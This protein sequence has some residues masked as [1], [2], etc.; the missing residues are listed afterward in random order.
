MTAPNKL[1][2]FDIDGTLVNSQHANM[3]AVKETWERAAAQ[4]PDIP[5]SC[6]T[7]S[8]Q[9]L[10]LTAGYDFAMS[11]HN[12]ASRKASAAG[13]GMEARFK[14]EDDIT[15]KAEQEF[16][17]GRLRE[18]KAQGKEQVIYDGVPQM[19]ETLKKEGY[20]L[21]VITKRGEA[22]ATPEQ[23]KLARYF[24]EVVTL[25]DPGTFK[26]PEH[27]REVMEKLGATPQTTVV[28]G[29]QRDDTEMA[30]S[31]GA[32]AIHV[33]WGHGLGIGGNHITRAETVAD[34]PDTVQTLLAAARRIGPTTSSAHPKITGTDSGK[35]S[36]TRR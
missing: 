32:H 24:D 28:V 22:F 2:V 8:D 13:L 26:S 34:I 19:L 16:Y 17:T 25:P 35:D 12:L 29:D 1:V 31:A 9:D 15:T 10:R 23:K 11:I 21:A 5:D 7:L 14:L 30:R 20:K 27:L 33:Q 18:L 36:G 4:I 3:Q 6:R